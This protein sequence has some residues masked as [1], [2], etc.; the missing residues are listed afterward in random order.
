MA[1]SDMVHALGGLCALSWKGQDAPPGAPDDAW[2]SFVGRL[3]QMPFGGAGV[4]LALDFQLGPLDRPMG[5][6]FEDPTVLSRGSPG[7][8]QAPPTY[9]T[10]ISFFLL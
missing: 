9:S 6:E 3:G 4:G 2:A 1:L 5:L 7:A 10:K 8:P